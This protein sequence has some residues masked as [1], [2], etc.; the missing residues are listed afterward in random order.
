[1]F[2]F[3]VI[4]LST[5]ANFLSYQ[6]FA[7]SAPTELIFV[8]LFARICQ[9]QEQLLPWWLDLPAAPGQVVSRKLWI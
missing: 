4:T 2:R 8:Y 9:P 7:L 6:T 1:M 3:L 5:W